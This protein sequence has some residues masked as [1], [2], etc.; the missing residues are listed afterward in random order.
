MLETILLIALFVALVTTA[1]FDTVWIGAAAIAIFAAATWLFGNAAAFVFLTNPVTLASFVV[2][3]L[4]IGA[5]WSMWKWR[6]HVKSEDVQA[7]L[8]KGMQRFVA[9]EGRKKER[10]GDD[11]IHKPF[12]ESSEFPDAARASYNKERIL[13]WIIFWPFSMIVYFFDDFLRDIALW[14]YERL[15]KVYHRITLS[16][17]SEEMKR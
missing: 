5:L 2:V 11:F 14:V 3:S 1:W 15:A 8:E 13:T 16:A 9:E 7:E 10:F 6:R 4:A 12:I 17:L